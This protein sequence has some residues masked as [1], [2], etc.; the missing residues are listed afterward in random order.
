MGK[1]KNSIQIILPSSKYSPNPSFI[2]QSNPRNENQTTNVSCIWNLPSGN[3]SFL[4]K[5]MLS[6]KTHDR[7]IK[8]IWLKK[9]DDKI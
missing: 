4:P 2:S 5:S 3:P 7:H 1:D 6:N 8:A 9:F